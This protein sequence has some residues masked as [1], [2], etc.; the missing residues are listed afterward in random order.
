LECN[1][2]NV[3]AR[4]LTTPANKFEVYVNQEKVGICTFSTEFSLCTIPFN[5]KS[6][7]TNVVTLGFNA[8]LLRSPKDVGLSNDTQNQG[9]GLQSLYLD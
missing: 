6:I 2:I 9:F 4:D 7:D 5:S 3:T 1:Y 8:T